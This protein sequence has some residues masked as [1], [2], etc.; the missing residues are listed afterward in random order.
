MAELFRVVCPNVAQNMI[1]LTF[2][3]NVSEDKAVY[4]AELVAC[5][6][7]GAVIPKLSKKNQTNESPT[8]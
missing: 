5:D 3:I 4:T 6:W 2:S 8:D 7:A 1:K